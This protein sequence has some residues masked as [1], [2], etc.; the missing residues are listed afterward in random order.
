M[1]W[2]MCKQKVA[3]NYTSKEYFLGMFCNIHVCINDFTSFY[4]PQRFVIRSVRP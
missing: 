3:E 1:V 2:Q 4:F